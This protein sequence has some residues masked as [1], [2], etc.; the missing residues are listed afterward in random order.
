MFLYYFIEDNSRHCDRRLL[1]AGAAA[2]A[3]MRKRGTLMVKAFSGFT[4]I[5]RSRSR[6]LRTWVVA[7]M[8]L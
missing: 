4:G 8:I 6:G 1:E 7:G 3:L 5:S 2:P